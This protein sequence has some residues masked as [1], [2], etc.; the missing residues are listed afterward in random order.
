MES[1]V[2]KALVSGQVPGIFNWQWV[3]P[4][5][6]P[7]LPDLATTEPICWA[8]GGNLLLLALGSSVEGSWV[9]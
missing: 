7:L 6:L 1:E 8:L 3:C 9:G 2:Q 5:W 4:L